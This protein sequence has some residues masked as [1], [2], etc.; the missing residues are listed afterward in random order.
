MKKLLMILG[1]FLLTI[2]CASTSRPSPE[3]INSAD[4]GPF[5][6]NY[7]ELIKGALNPSLLDPYSAIYSFAEPQKGWNNM[8]SEPIYGWTVCGTVNAKN[9]F[10]G[11]VGIRP[12]YSMINNGVVVRFI[13]EA[14]TIP[15]S[16]F[17]GFWS[18]ELGTY[19]GLCGR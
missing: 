6:S 14:M 19:D 16:V 11:Y 12:F 1:I 9:R 13:S 15:D 17:W 18:H 2:S 3:Q 7:Q 4:C 8:G 10:G 5:P